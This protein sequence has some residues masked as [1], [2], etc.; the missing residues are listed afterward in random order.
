MMNRLLAVAI[1]VYKVTCYVDVW[2]H[3][4]INYIED[5]A[6]QIVFGWKFHEFWPEF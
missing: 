3:R 2:I 1:S 5:K 6:T 4:V